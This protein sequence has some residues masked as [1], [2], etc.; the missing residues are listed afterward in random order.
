MN[1]KQWI[2]C[3]ILDIICLICSII[4]VLITL[5]KSPLI[6]TLWGI[7]AGMRVVCLIFTLKEKHTA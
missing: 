2:F 3:I 6:P 1:K 4:I 7:I 5:N